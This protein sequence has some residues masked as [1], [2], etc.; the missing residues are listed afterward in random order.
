VTTRREDLAGSVALITGATGGIGRAVAAGL[1]ASGVHVFAI[2]R[3]A[4]RLEHVGRELNAHGVEFG[5]TVGDITDPAQI[6]RLAEAA[7]GWRG[8]VDIIVN[9]AG[10]IRRSTLE[11]TTDQEWDETFATNARAPFLLTRRVGER[12]LDGDGG[13]VVNITSMAGD[14]VT[15]APVAYG[16]SKAALIYLTK[17][18]AVRWAPKVRV[19]A[20]APGYVRTELNEDWLRDEDNH[21]Y[22][23]ARTPLDRVATPDDIVGAVLFLASPAAG[24]VTGHN[25]VV[26]GGWTAQ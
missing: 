3:R 23:L 18:F 20:V 8:R 7:W 11:E 21:E 12:M 9:A 13:A 5:S 16:A 1:A 19:N 2:G 15:G 24:Y 6:E 10:V 14:V 25:L 17:Y 22:V 26:D 4:A